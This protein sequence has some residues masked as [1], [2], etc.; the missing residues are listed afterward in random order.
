[1]LQVGQEPTTP[2]FDF[3]KALRALDSRPHSVQ[4]PASP[5]KIAVKDTIHSA[6]ITL[7]VGTLRCYGKVTDQHGHQGDRGWHSI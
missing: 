4:H 6:Y 7:E 1:M 5:C 3:A 2:M